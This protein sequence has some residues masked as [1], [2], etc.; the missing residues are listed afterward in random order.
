MGRKLSVVVKTR[1]KKKFV[2]KIDDTHYKIGVKEEA[3][4]GKANEAVIDALAEYFDLAKSRI[5][6]CLGKTR[7][8]KVF[9]IK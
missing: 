3:V 9:E 8:E 2:E 7:K 4:E 6:L 1:S 5:S